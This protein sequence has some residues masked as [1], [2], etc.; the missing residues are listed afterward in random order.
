MPTSKT[1]I[2]G[3]APGGAASLTATVRRHMKQADIICG[4]QRLLDMFPSLAS[5]KVPVGNNLAEIAGLIKRN[6]GRKRVVV[7]ASGDPGF[8]GIAGYLTSALGKS[9]VK[10]IPNVSAMQLAFARIGESWDDADFASVH[11]RPIEDIFA[12]IRSSDKIGIFTDG[13]HTPSAIARVLLDSGINGYRAYV[14]E[15]LGEKNERIIKTSLKGLCKREFSPLNI[16]ILLRDKHKPAGLISP[17]TLGIPDREFY[18]R[19]PKEG[20]ITK[21]EVRAV[22]LAKIQIAEN[23]IVWDIG[24][25]SGAISIEASF[26]ARKGR[27]YAIEKNDADITIIRKNIRKFKATNVDVVHAFAPEGL[28]ILPAPSSVFIGGSGGKIE[29]I[30]EFVV[31]K[32]KPGGRLVINLVGLENLGMALDALQKSGFKPEITLVNIARST[33]V[34]ALTRLA[35]LNPVFIVIAGKQEGEGFH[36]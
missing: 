7:L 13:Q 21:Q 25:G 36:G 34:Q 35:A 19:R 26:L 14:C 24:A 9:A 5:K 4:G 16:L 1:L 28:D 12:K 18:Q 32:L 27:I 8:Y 3:I 29:E 30:I 33:A 20:L 23:S 22:S 31:R 10:I 6:Q 15:N 11:A 2:I 17:R